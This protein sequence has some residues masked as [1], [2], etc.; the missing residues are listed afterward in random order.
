MLVTSTFSFSHNVLNRLLSQGHLNLQLSG[1]GLTLSHTI[2]TF[3]DLEKRELL[4]IISPFPSVFF[5][6]I[7]HKFCDFRI[8]SNSY[9]EYGSRLTHYLTMPHFDTQKIYSRRKHCNKPF[10]LFP[11]CF[12]PYK[13]LIF[14]LICA[15]KCRLQFVSIW[16][17]L[18]FCH[19]VMG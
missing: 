9:T 3:N 6:P 10:L 17:S 2:L 8:Y 11:Q 16:T 4:K 13:A 15:L 12:L 5:Y 18:K 7:K 19:L 1:K 14:H